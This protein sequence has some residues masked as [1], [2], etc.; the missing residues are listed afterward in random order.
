MLERNLAILHASNDT[1]ILSSEPQSPIQRGEGR[2][3]EKGGGGGGE[4][5]APVYPVLSFS[6][7][8]SDRYFIVLASKM[9]FL[10]T[11]VK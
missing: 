10:K 9:Q 8:S 6:L 7:L 4:H 2:S 11:V 5:M 1:L 3:A